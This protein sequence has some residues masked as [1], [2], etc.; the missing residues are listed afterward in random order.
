[1]TD[2][3]KDHFSSRSVDYS[4][5]RPTYPPA[6]AQELAR[7]APGRELALDC[8]CGS[9]QF[10]PLL[11]EVF[12]RVEATDA[13]EKQIAAAAPHPRITYR[14]AKAEAS[15][16]PDASVDLLTVAQALHWFD[17]DA[18]YAE[19][20]RVLKPGGVVALITYGDAE[21]DGAIGDVLNTFSHRTIGRFWPPERR[22]VMEAYRSLPF[23]FEEE[24]VIETTMTADWPLERLLGYVDTWSAMRGAE[25]ELGRG[26]YEVFTREL[27]ELWG[28]PAAP[29]EVRWKLTARVGRA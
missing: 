1:M 12:D 14:V 24:P 28:D 10:T 29:R 4:L 13:S 16:L 25:R 20:R 11:A 18:F 5:Y 21:L 27:G 17:L 22:L 8:G 2:A 23:P 26:P 15:G 7:R 9:G 19:A 3:F 6:L